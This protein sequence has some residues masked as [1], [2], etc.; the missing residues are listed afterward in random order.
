MDNNM[1]IHMNVEVD[2]I[3]LVAELR[4]NKVVQT[5]NSHSIPGIHRLDQE[6]RCCFTKWK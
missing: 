3:E 5:W 1:E 6:K 4:L 2:K